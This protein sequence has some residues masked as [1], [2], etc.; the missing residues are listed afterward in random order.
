MKLTK[1]AG[2]QS[3]KISKA[4]WLTIGKKAGWVAT[5]TNQNVG[6]KYPEPTLNAPPH[7]KPERCPEC[8]VDLQDDG[9]CPTCRKDV[10]SDQA[11]WS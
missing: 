11:N 4:E 6:E 1:T 7:E 2:K 8:N 10:R 9:I 3:L 5:G